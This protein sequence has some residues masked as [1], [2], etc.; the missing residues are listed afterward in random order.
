[1]PMIAVS[2]LFKGFIQRNLILSPLTVF[3]TLFIA[4]MGGSHPSKPGF[5]SA[6]GIAAG[7]VYGTPLGVLI[8]LVVLGQCS[9]VLL[10]IAPLTA[11]AVSG[12]GIGIAALLLVV[13]GNLV[14]DHLH[15]FRKGDY[16]L[17]LLALLLILLYAVLVSFSAK[18]P[19][20]WLSR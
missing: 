9:D 8:G 19:L 3:I 12:L 7:F 18:I 5:L 4:I 20:S 14:I 2:E 16:T 1:M 15:P 10:Q 13:A 6:L 11:P 17:S